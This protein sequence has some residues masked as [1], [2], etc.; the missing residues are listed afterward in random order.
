MLRV[1]LKRVPLQ[2]AVTG[3]YLIRNRRTR[4]VYVGSSW[5]IGLRWAQHVEALNTGRHY[6]YRLQA[7]WRTHGAG[8]FEFK[9][10]ERTSRDRRWDRE[11]YWID[12]LHAAD[13]KHGYNIMA[14]VERPDGSLV[15]SGRGTRQQ[16]QRALRP[17]RRKTLGADI[18]R[19]AWRTLVWRA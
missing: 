2:T 5:N 6:N 3:V 11:Q 14:I 16:R 7:A 13:P 12:R 15:R 8:A 4:L 9:V 19:A 18:I 10:I 1:P 17:P